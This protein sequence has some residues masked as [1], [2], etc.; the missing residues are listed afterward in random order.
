MYRLENERRETRCGFDHRIL[1]LRQCSAP[2][3]WVD[4]LAKSVR[5]EFEVRFPMGEA[6]TSFNPMYGQGISLSAGQ[7]RALQSALADGMDGLAARYFDGCEA[8]NHV[9]WS[10]M[11][12]RDLE[13]ASSVGKRPRDIENRW[14]TAAA[15]RKLAETD[16]EVHR[17]SV[18]VTHLLEPPSKL[19]R[20]DII[21]RTRQL[22]S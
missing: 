15:I 8:L 7:A 6:S 17:L 13:H 9:G 2:I 14:K 12:T 1:L 3:S 10:V 16:A 4:L 22:S 19:A 18:H 11:E 5:L 21:D 20:Q